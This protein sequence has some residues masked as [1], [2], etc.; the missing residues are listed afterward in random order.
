[1]ISA[2]SLSKSFG[3]RVLFEGASFRLNPGERYGLVG[4]NGSGKT[5]LLN[6]LAGDMEASAGSVDMPRRIRLGVLRQDRF[7][8]E[9]EEILQVTLMGNEELWRAMAERDE[10]LA[11]AGEHFDADR[12]SRVEEVFERHD[13]YTAEPRAAAILEGLGLPA[14][15]HGD[16]LSTLSGGFRLRVLLAQVLASAPDALL[17]DEPTNHLD[18]VSIRWLEKFLRGFR[19]PVVVISHDHRFLDNVATHILDIDYETVIGYPGNYTRFLEAKAAERERREKEIA[20]RERE[21]AH[22]RKFVDRF[23]AKASKARQAQSKLR[24]IEK[25]TEAL[26]ELPKSSRRYPTFRFDQRWPSGR[27]V[28]RVKGVGKSFGDNQVLRDVDLRVGRGDRLAIVGPNGIG[29]STLLKI[30]VGRLEADEGSVDWGYETWPGYFAQDPKDHLAAGGADGAGAGAPERRTA[31]AW[32]SDYCP[33]KGTGFARGKMGMV[34]FTGDDADKRLGALSGGESARLVLCSLMIRAPNVLVLDEPTNHLDLE[35]IE[36]LVNGLNHFAGTLVFVSHDRW[37]VG[38]LAN[39][40]VEITEDGMRDYRGTY[41]E[42]VHHCGDDHLDTDTVLEQARA[43]ARAESRRSRAEDGE[44]LRGTSQ[45]TWGKNRRARARR[46]RRLR[47]LEAR[48]AKLAE[49]IDGAEARVSE[50]DAVFASPTFYEQ[51]APEEV[52]TLQAERQELTGRIARLMREWEAVEA[53]VEAAVD[54][55]GGS[56]NG[57]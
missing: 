27:E 3:E 21:I 32:I 18:I 39:R 37:F 13:G 48:G 22:H 33:G 35:S 29:K 2:T 51:S 5:T 11:R 4:A 54:A 15:V 10:V 20:V 31:E 43:D 47:E 36:A 25:R 14:K 9:D 34:L 1:M 50:I 6:I 44:A 26:V 42:Y 24:L 38:R 30:A 40:I 52:Q 12:F 55:A 19:G 45:D 8:Y 56:R 41:E 46:D 16:P 28:L 49:Q 23:R 57:K 7:L 53:E 17:L